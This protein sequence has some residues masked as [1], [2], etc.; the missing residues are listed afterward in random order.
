M[1]FPQIDPVALQIGPVAIRWYGLMYLIGFASAWWLGLKRKASLGSSTTDEQ[2][3]DLIFYCALGAILGGRLGYMLFYAWPEL[4]HDPMSLFKIWQGGMSFHGG[5]AGVLLAAGYFAHKN[6]HTWLEVTDFVAPLVPIGLG[7]GRLGNFINGELWGRPSDV[8]W[9]IIFPHVDELPRHPSQ[10]YECLLEGVILFIVLW[11]FSS[12]PRPRG[13]ISAAFLLGYS[14]AR[15]FVENFREPDVQIGFLW[16][17]LTM[18]QWLSVPM[19]AFGLL[20]WVYSARGKT[21]G[22]D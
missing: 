14:S 16:H 15:I 13:Q 2:V 7:A 18:G 6:K 22:H 19:V 20:L 17:G 1:L 11:W 5:C 8:P 4:M 12:K 21:N 10:L 9:A 3:S